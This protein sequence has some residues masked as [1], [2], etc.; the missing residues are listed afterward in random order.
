MSECHKKQLFFL[1]KVYVCNAVKIEWK[2]TCP[3]KLRRGS[4]I[5]SQAEHH[6]LLFVI[7]VDGFFGQRETKRKWSPSTDASISTQSPG[8]Q[9]SKHSHPACMY[10][11][12]Q[13]NPTS[14]LLLLLLTQKLLLFSYFDV[15]S[16]Y[17]L[18]SSCQ[19]SYDTVSSLGQCSKMDNKQKWMCTVC[20]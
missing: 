8:R 19:H 13:Y 5:E 17:K 10:L 1:A 9:A 11:I 3:L 18:Y 2:R 4:L 12:I 6:S 7:H 15:P 16:T 14:L 20:L